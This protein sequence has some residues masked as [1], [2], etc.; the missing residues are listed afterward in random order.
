[1]KHIFSSFYAKLSALFLVLIV[2]LG[3]TIAALSVQAGLHLA[4]EA[5]QKLNRRLA[6]NLAEE[7]QPHLID[8]IDHEL[9]DDKIHRM[10]LVNPRIEI[11]LLEPDGH[12][13]ASFLGPDKRL[14]MTQVDLAPLRRYIDGAD[15]PILGSDPLQE[16]RRKPF[17]AAHIMIMGEQ[18]CYLYIILGSQEYDSALGMVQNSYIMQTTLRGLA[19]ALLG[20]GVVGVLLFGL[21]T[22]RLRAM[23]E[24]VGAF[25][26]GQ[27]DRRIPV[28]AA[29]EIGQL[30][31]S[32]NQMADALAANVEDLQRTD[33]LRRELIANVSHDLRSP[34]A[35][36]QGYLETIL[37]K[38]DALLPEERRR[39]MEVVLKNTRSLNTLVEELFELS[40]LDAQ[41]IQPQ[42]EAFSITELVHDLVMQFQ[43]RA[44]QRGVRLAAELPEHLPPVHADIRL[45]E[46][47]LSNLIDNALRFTPAGGHVRV[48]PQAQ[49]GGVCVRI[50]DT[51]TGI[52]AEDLPHIF[53][54]FYRVEKSRTR[55]RGGTGLGLAIANKIA[56]LHGGG[57]AVES[58]MGEGAT[59]SFRLPLQPSGHPQPT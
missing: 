33:R 46:R 57:L 31:A 50:I 32:F 29:D 6:E 55:D 22:R 24:V 18:D 23:R 51:G 15:L 54:R 44:E 36:M 41:Q 4:D 5:E 48:V 49:E 59:F 7:F 30:A 21:L 27:L 12:I 25:S 13:K 8:R 16:S 52:P 35:A 37:I 56:E 2:V 19:L 40:K 20:T 42:L 43:P 1:M 45:V 39:Y 28:D 9:I 17:S 14:E 10:M 58:T 3:A 53:E 34:L 11:Y 47:A 26:D 38:E